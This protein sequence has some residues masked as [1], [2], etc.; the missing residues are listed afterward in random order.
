[1]YAWMTIRYGRLISST[2]REHYKEPINRDLQQ[3][4]LFDSSE[5]Q[6]DT[7]MDIFKI[8][9]TIGELVAGGSILAFIQF[10]INRH[11]K[12][13]D[14]FAEIMETMQDIRKEVQ[15]IKKDASKSEAIRSRTSILR[16]QDEL[17]NDIKHSRE[18]FDQVLD[19]IETYEKFCHENPDFQNGRTKAAAQYIREERDRLFKEH[20]L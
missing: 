18:Y 8:L 11:D 4:V 9:V 3:R 2:S 16:F 19:D 5:T 15:E 13:H 20:K 6:E 10:L 17:Y 14:R 1:M 12:K 7:P